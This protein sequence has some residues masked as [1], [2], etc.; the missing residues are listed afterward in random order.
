M[1]AD[2]RLPDYDS[3]HFVLAFSPVAGFAPEC[4]YAAASREG[5]PTIEA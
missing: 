3:A 1:T 2:G 4:E 5:Y